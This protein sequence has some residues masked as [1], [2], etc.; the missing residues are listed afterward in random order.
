MLDGF[1]KAKAYSEKARHNNVSG[2]IRPTPLTPL[3]DTLSPSPFKPPMSASSCPC[4]L[5]QSIHPSPESFCTTPFYQA[6]A[7]DID[8]PVTRRVALDAVKVF[9][10]S[11]DVL[12]ILSH[13]ASLLEVLEF[14]P[15]DLAGWEKQPSRKDISQWRFLNEFRKGSTTSVATTTL[16]NK[17]YKQ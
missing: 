10:T 16:D 12:V 17:T 14:F 9:D 5:F 11:Q 6:P 15:K 2:E 3:P 8:D 4:S 7:N 13:D 1:N